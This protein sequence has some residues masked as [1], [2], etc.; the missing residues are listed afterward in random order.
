MK[1]HTR[2]T[3][4]II[5]AI[6]YAELNGYWSLYRTAIPI[7]AELELQRGKVES[8]RRR[9]ADILPQVARGE[10]LEQRALAFSVYAKVLLATDPAKSRGEYHYRK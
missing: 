7:F 4:I 10:D 3:F 6:H 9:L 1:N 8:A 5:E 2:A